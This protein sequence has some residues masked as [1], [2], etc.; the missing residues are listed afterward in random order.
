VLTITTIKALR[1]DTCADHAKCEASSFSMC[2]CKFHH[3]LAIETPGDLLLV[4]MHRTKERA[5]D[6]AHI[7][8]MPILIGFPKHSTAA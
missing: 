5:E 2:C 7:T 1:N 6:I 4:L 3:E 8:L